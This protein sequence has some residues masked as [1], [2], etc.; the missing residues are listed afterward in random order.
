MIAQYHIVNIH[1][2]LVEDPGSYIYGFADITVISY[3]CARNKWLRQRNLLRRYT[4]CHGRMI[5]KSPWTFKLR[6]VAFIYIWHIADSVRLKPKYTRLAEVPLYF[7][8]TVE[9]DLRR[10]TAFGW[11][12]FKVNDDLEYGIVDLQTCLGFLRS[13]EGKS[14]E[15]QIAL[16]VI[17]SS[18]L[19]TTSSKNYNHNN[20]RRA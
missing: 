16:V 14:L 17:A 10:I 9:I 20:L 12:L 8:T 13:Q 1:D 15:K 7:C 19:H 6:Y 2:R 3:L 4:R 5:K 11:K 18:G